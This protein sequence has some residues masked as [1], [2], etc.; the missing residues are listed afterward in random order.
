M[1]FD[2]IMFFVYIF[3]L[4]LALLISGI[5]NLVLFL[6]A[7]KGSAKRRGTKIAMIISFSVFGVIISLLAFL[8]IT[9]MVGV[10]NM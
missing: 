4:P 3:G 7:P 9:L 10:A 1:T 6:K 8:F 5:I 2:T